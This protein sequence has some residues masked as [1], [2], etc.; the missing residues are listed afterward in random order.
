MTASEQAKA[1]G[2]KSLIEVAELIDKTTATLCNWFNDNPV[3]FNSVIIGL[4]KIKEDD[5]N[6]TD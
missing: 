5:L 4:A 1:A 2:F 3:L 6:V